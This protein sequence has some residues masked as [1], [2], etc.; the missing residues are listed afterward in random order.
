LKALDYYK[1]YFKK[2]LLRK[3]YNEKNNFSQNLEDFSICSI[4]KGNSQV[5]GHLGM[6][7]G[8]FTSVLM[9]ELNGLLAWFYANEYPVAT[10]DL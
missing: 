10:M 2:S 8:G 4:F 3:I 7:H 1:V 5:Q 6:F 9:D